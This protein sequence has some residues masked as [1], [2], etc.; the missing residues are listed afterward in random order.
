M[1][2]DYSSRELRFTWLT[3]EWPVHFVLPYQ[4]KTLA[5]RASGT[6]SCL[7]QVSTKGP[8]LPSLVFCLLCVYPVR[9]DVLASVV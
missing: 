3:L 6:L 1:F 2:S 9:V 5:C 7:Q 4:S 8:T